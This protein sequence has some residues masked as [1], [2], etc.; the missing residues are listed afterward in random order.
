MWGLI[1]NLHSDDKICPN[2]GRLHK[3]I[4]MGSYNEK[5]MIEINE[6]I[7]RITDEEIMDDGRFA[8]HPFLHEVCHQNIFSFPLLKELWS[9]PIFKKYWNNHEYQDKYG[10]TVLERL[11]ISLY[12]VDTDTEKFKWIK[13]NMKVI[14]QRDFNGICIEKT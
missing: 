4:N 13:D 12:P 11:S 14:P 3:Y 2:I 7:D 8:Q 6:L 10:N 5:I 1:H 9:K